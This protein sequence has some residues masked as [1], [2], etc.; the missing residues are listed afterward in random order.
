MKNSLH[1]QS[2]SICQFDDE[3]SKMSQLNTKKTRVQ[4]SL[5]SFLFSFKFRTFLLNEKIDFEIFRSDVT[6]LKN[7][8]ERL[9]SSLKK[10]RRTIE[11]LTKKKDHYKKF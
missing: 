6:L 10:S 8:C 1:R 5:T 11:T 4:Y 3:E 7:Q 2:F 9:M